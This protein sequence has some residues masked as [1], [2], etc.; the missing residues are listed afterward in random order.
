[1]MVGTHQLNVSYKQLVK[2]CEEMGCGLVF[3]H[4]IFF[5]G[6]SCKILYYLC[7]QCATHPQ[8]LPCVVTF[9]ISLFLF[10]FCFVF[11]FFLLDGSLLV[12]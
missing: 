9:I 3:G 10:L 2:H 11:L 12:F 6:F 5:K 8:G 4:G 1:M 7:H